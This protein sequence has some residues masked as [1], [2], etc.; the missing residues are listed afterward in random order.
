M[1]TFIV[2]SWQ[3]APKVFLFLI[4]HFAPL[5]YIDIFLVCVFSFPLQYKFHNCKAIFGFV[6]DHNILYNN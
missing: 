3:Y 1:Y 5:L 6:K 4:I 2:G